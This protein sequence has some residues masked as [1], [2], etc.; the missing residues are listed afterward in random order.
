[1]PAALSK[2]SSYT[3]KTFTIAL[4]L[5]LCSSYALA[6]ASYR[7]SVKDFS[8]DPA[9]VKALQQGIERMKAKS[10]ANPM[11]ADFRTSFAYWSNTHGFF[12]TG[13]NA[14]DLKAYIASRMPS[15]A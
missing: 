12:G 7:I 14:T 8:S 9:K 10:Q 11:S 1:M 5:L 15:S 3:K 13:K 6:E 4:C 2:K